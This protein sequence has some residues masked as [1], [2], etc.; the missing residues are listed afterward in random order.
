MPGRKSECAG[1][2][3]E[4]C[5]PTSARPFCERPLYVGCSDTCSQIQHS[6]Y[7]GQPMVGRTVSEKERKIKGE[8]FCTVLPFQNRLPPGMR[9]ALMSPEI[10]HVRIILHGHQNEEAGL[11][12]DQPH[13]SLRDQVCVQE[14][15]DSISPSNCVKGT[16]WTRWVWKMP[17]IL[18]LC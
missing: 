5:T 18:P 1:G 15:G 4:G 14:E 17:F 16:K 9:A 13:R 7:K 6:K 3:Q 11:A 12:Q 10:W 8:P 2:P